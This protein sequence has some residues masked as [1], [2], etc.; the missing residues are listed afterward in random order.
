MPRS[1]ED[2]SPRKI[3]SRKLTL[4]DIEWGKHHIMKHLST[5]S[6]I[7][8]FPYGDIMEIPNEKLLTLLQ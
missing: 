3:F 7:D 6:G 5:A 8:D 2:R 1:N 4:E